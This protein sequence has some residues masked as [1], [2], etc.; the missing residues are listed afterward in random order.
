MVAANAC[1]RSKLYDPQVI[2]EK[3]KSYVQSS[4]ITIAD[5]NLL[6]N[7]LNTDPCPSEPL[8]IIVTIGVD[9]AMLKVKLLY[10]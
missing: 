8:N 10:N 4:T 1:D 5:G 2:E 9:S 3:I 6:T 7:N